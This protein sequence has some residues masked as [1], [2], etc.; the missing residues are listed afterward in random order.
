MTSDLWYQTTHQIDAPPQ[1]VYDALW[2]GDPPRQPEVE[3]AILEAHLIT[4]TPGQ[5][6]HVQQLR[7]NN[8]SLDLI[9][10]A[11]VT[12]AD[13]PYVYQVSQTPDGLT[14]HDPAERS[15]PFTKTVVADLDTVFQQTFGNDPLSTDVRFDLAESSGGTQVTLTISVPDAPKQGYFRRYFWRRHVKKQSAF[16]LSQIVAAL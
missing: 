1:A 11:T 4:G 16:T 12:I 10:I 6:G 13:P 3:G 5:A 9:L 7:T 15:V 2:K 8:G 14:R